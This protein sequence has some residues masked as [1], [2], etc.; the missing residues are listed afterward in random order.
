[1]I[2]SLPEDMLGDDTSVKP[3]APKPAAPAKPK[4]ADVA[5]IAER[6]AAAERPLLIAGGRVTGAD[7][8]EALRA[9][10]ESWNL[11]V[12]LSFRRQDLFDHDHP[13]F[14]CHLAFNMPPV[15]AD[16]LN[17]ADLVVAVGTRLGDVVT[18]G[19]KIPSAPKPKQPLIHVYPDGKRIGRNFET[20]MAIAADANALLAALARANAPPAPDGRKA[21]IAKLHAMDAERRAWHPVDAPDGVSF[22]TVV[23]EIAR[24]A[25]DDLIF[26]VDAGNFSTWVHRHFPFKASHLMLGAVAGSMGMGVPAAV[27]GSLR[28]PERPVVCVV[29]D[30]GFQMTGN[31]LAVAVER[32]LPI[33]VFVSNNGSYG[34]IRLYQEKLYPG[35]TKATRLGNPDFAELAHAHGAAGLRIETNA[36]VGPVVAAAMSTEG[37]VVVDVRASLEY[38]SAY[39]RISEIRKS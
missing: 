9:V 25:D 2:V 3:V 22:G 23:A 38:L 21:W 4:N 16:T 12:A 14:A 33:R 18:Q 17:E 20:A 29:G 10:A 39:T 11:P 19:Y 13:N 27:A 34:T 31:E 7:G 35:R 15:F 36:D 28:Y 30:G 6:I 24:A 5:A 8:R 32:N 26:A 1:V 37:P